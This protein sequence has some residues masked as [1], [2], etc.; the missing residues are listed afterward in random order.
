MMQKKEVFKKIILDFQKTKISLIRRDF[1]FPLDVKKVITLYGPRR[2]GKTYLFYQSIQDLLSKK[3]SLDQIVYINFEDERIL[4][5]SKEDWELLLDAYFELYPENINKKIF[6]FLDEIQE[7]PFW[8]K[9]TRRLSEK[10]N[11]RVFLTG[12]S[13]KL[14]SKE[15]STTLRGRTLSYFL[16]PFSFREFLRAKDIEIGHHF[17]YT[18]LR[19]KIKHLFQEYLKFGGFPEVFD[20]EETIKVQ[21][22]QGYFDLIFY[23]DIVER[24][25]I[26]NFDL[27][28]EL[29]RYLLTNFS[30]L[31]SLSGY[32][33]FLKSRGRKIGK[34]TLFEYLACLEEVNFARQIS[35]FDFSLKK[36][37]VNPKK[38]YCI[39]TGLITAVSAQFS[40][41]RGRYLEN[42]AFLELLRRGKDIYYF[43]D[44]K[45]GEVDFLIVEKNKPFQLIQVTRELDNA[46]VREREVAPLIRSAK[47][48]NIKECVILTE[49][50]RMEFYEEKVKIKVLPL[51]YWLLI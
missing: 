25:K 37:I 40:E 39:D 5:F 13:S 18:A 27:M 24:Y 38:N 26:R 28:K 2:C 33:N 41:N 12:S 34:D 22:L 10:N 20:K 9:F 50:Q 42:L 51:W 32:Y 30:S 4:P 3:I 23:K 49:D 35:L 8:D 11:F 6:L 29:M 31:F 43:K 14:F 46:K 47:Q 48:F 44:S 16:T 15:I 21:I 45:G 19:H 7:T 1:S 36:Q 17:E